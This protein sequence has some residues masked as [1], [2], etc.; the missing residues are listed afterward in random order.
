MKETSQ[1]LNFQQIYFRGQRFDQP[2]IVC[3]VDHLAKHL[4]K[5][6]C[7][8]SPFIV[9]T[10]FNHIK[11][12]ITYYA[13][14]KVGKIAVILDPQLKSIELDEIVKDVDPAAIVFLDEK[15]ISFDYVG[16]IMFRNQDKSFIIDSDLKDVCTIAYTNAEDGFS[17]GA[18]LT[19]KNIMA[20]VQA[21][22]KTNKI[23]C[24]SVI[25]ALLPFSH[26][27]GFM[28]GV[29]T[30]TQ[31]GASGLI[32]ELNLLK[33]AST[34]KEIE[35]F[36]VTHLHTV[37]SVY[38]VLSK[39]PNVEISIQN[40][41]EF[42]SGGIQLSQFIFDNF[43]LKTKRK[44]REGYGLTECS[45][46]VAGNFQEE[47]SVFGSFG[48]PFPGCEIKIVDDQDNECEIEKIGEICV[49][50][51]MVFKGYFNHEITTKA[52]LKDR[53]LHTGD[54]GKKDWKGFYYFCGLKKE[55]INIAGNKVYPKK[56]ERLITMNVNV[57]SAKVFSE[58]SILQ[59]HTVGVIVK[60]KYNSSKA[61]EELRIWCAKNINNNILPK[62][63]LFE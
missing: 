19:E 52:I 13:I 49:R 21:I 23:T 10:A 56:L 45:P 51:D 17:K 62:S 8:Q 26:L 63:Y 60:L 61:Q 58:V 5:N 28:H 48:K 30:L 31:S 41:K 2:T 55:M 37:P 18:M 33:I 20:E 42:Y 7:S 15:N 1:S 27:Y 9:F 39:V 22:I 36:K 25:C 34:L 50:S 35:C 24:D 44:I 59:G 57:F 16:E 54:Y 29:L 3:A 38:Y 47:D 14:L 4:K 46:A 53:W 43:Y 32:T 40:V 6:I 12:V 11:T